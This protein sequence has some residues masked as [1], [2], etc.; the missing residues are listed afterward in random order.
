MTHLFTLISFLAYAGAALCLLLYRKDGARHR[1]H[2]SW[3]AWALLVILAG[4]CV[5]LLVDGHPVSPF[6]ACR[7]VLFSLFVFGSRGN[8][9]RLLRSA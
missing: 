4:S 6:E 8:V 1:Q 5:E 7:A 2:V 3:V 9:A